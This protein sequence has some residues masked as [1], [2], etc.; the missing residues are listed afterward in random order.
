MLLLKILKSQFFKLEKEF[1]CWHPLRYIFLPLFVYKFICI[2]R[3]NNFISLDGLHP[4]D[5]YKYFGRRVGSPWPINSAMAIYSQLWF[6]QYDNHLEVD[7][8]EKE[9]LVF[10]HRTSRFKTGCSTITPSRL[11]MLTPTQYLFRLI[12]LQYDTP[13]LGSSNPRPLSQKATPRIEL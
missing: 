5:T 10:D 11:F 6:P 2:Q 8:L 12:N 3:F 7:F 9:G 4:W 1:L 13:R